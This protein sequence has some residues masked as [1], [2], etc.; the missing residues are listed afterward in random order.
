MPLPG[1]FTPSS[2]TAPPSLS[3]TGG[4]Y[5]SAARAWEWEGQDNWEGWDEE[6]IWSRGFDCA[7]I[8]VHLPVRQALVTI[9]AASNQKAPSLSLHWPCFNSCDL[10]KRSAK[11]TS[12]IIEGDHTP[13]YVPP[14][15]GKGQQAEKAVGS[16]KHFFW[17]LNCFGVKT[18]AWVSVWFLGLLIWQF[19]L[20]L[21]NVP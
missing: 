9:F 18:P 1:S 20:H 5:Q 15:L 17:R 21:K 12:S 19:N 11:Q 10:E 7:I 8:L 4:N 2:F 14:P 6:I 3:L 16:L 13:Q